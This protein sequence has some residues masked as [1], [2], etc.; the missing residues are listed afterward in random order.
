MLVAAAA[1]EPPPPNSYG[2]NLSQPVASVIIAVNRWRCSEQNIQAALSFTPA[3]ES[4]KQRLREK[5]R[6]LA[7]C[8][9]K[10]FAHA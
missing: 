9:G 2:F 4:D 5:N 1:G 7:L 3:S 8:L 6:T 10:F